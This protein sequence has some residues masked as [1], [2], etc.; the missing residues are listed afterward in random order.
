MSKCK[1]ERGS[2]R[3]MYIRGNKSKGSA[4]QSKKGKLRPGAF[5]QFQWPRT[6]GTDPIPLLPRNLFFKE[7]FKD[8]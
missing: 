6:N 5:H 2:E 4:N 1:K 3:E 7:R 8:L